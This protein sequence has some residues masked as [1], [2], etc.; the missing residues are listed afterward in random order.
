MDRVARARA[1]RNVALLIIVAL[2]QKAARCGE[3]SVWHPREIVVRGPAA[4]E[5]DNDPNPF[6]DIRLTVTL[7][8]PTGQSYVVPGFFDGDGKSEPRGDVW[9]ARFTPDEAGTWRYRAEFRAGPHVAIDL[10]PDAGTALAEFAAEGTVEVG[11]RDEEAPGFEKWGRLESVPGNYLK[12]H[13]GPY[14][15]RGG[16]DEPENFLAYAGFPRTPPTHRYADHVVDW[17][18]GDP[19]WGDG[20]GRGII[21]ALNYLAQHEVNSIYFLLMNIGGDGRDV[22]PWTGEP[23]RRGSADNDNLHYDIS[24]LRQW[25]TVFRHAQQRGIFLHAVFNEAEEANKRELDDGELGPE[26]KLYY[27]EMIARFGHHLALQWNLCEEY[28]LNFDFG[29]QRLRD[30]ADYVRAVDPYDHPIAVHSAGDPV[31]ALEFTFG[32]PRFDVM[33]VQLNQRPIHLVTEALREASRS[34]GRPVPVS[35]DEFTLD[36]GQRASH[37]PVDDA[38]G[39]RREKLWPTY[40]SGGMIEFI[41]QD[42]LRTDS[43]KTPERE[44]LWRAMAIARRFMEEQLPFWEMEPCDALSQGAA[45]L[46]VG[47]GRG[48]TVSLGAQVFAKPGEAYAVYFPTASSTGTLDLTALTGQA[49]LR[50]FNPRSGEFV[51]APRE[52]AAGALVALGPP[53]ADSELDWVAL[54]R[55]GNVPAPHF[56]GAHWERRDPDDAGLDADRLAQF[57]ERVGGDGCIVRDGCLVHEWGDPHAHGDWASAAKPVLSTLL[58][59]AVEKGK[60]ASVDAPVRDAGWPLREKDAGMTFRHLANMTSGYARG[61]APGEAWAYNDLAIELYARSLERVFGKS[62]DAALREGLPEL[63]FEDGEFFGSRD[64]VGVRASP[65]DFAR[66]AWFWLNEGQWNGQPLL[67]TQTMRDGLRPGVPAD[68]PRTKLEGEDYLR[69]GSYGGG[70]DQAAFG[71]G[72]YGFNFWFNRPMAGRERCWMSLP[73]D[74]YQAN[75]HWSRHTVTVVPGLQLVIV[76]RRPA[77]DRLEDS[78]GAF[79]ES[80]RLVAEAGGYRPPRPA[81]PLAPLGTAGFES[82]AHHWRRIRDEARVIQAEANQPAYDPARVDEIAANLLLFQRDNGG[83]PKDYDMH[84]VLTPAQREAVLVSRGRVDTSFDNSNVHSQVDYLA[85]AY[86]SGR[87]SA[88]RAACLRGFDFMLAAQYSDGGFPQRWPDPQGYAAHIT[89]NDGVMIGILNVLHDAAR[90]APHWSWLDAERRASAQRAVE[91]GVDCV[92]KCQIRDGARLTGWCQQHARDSYEPV[93]ARTFELAS[94]CPQETTEIVQFL[95]RQRDPAPEVVT[96][97]EAA[98]RWLAESQLRGVGVDRVPAPEIEFERHRA[99]FDVVV[100]EDPA[101]P[102]IWARHYELGTQRPVFAGRDGVKRYALSEI[103]RERRTGTPWYGVWPQTLL[104]EQYPAWR[105]K[106]EAA[107]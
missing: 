1:A 30:F 38:A 54:V 76:A 52:I 26:R 41:L 74:A 67:A 81:R 101:A 61:E 17:R 19:D 25:E 7:T 89:F 22:W 44:A 63:Q 33:S 16:V 66:L 79:D 70:S 58:L 49:T 98:A 65:R 40:F 20:Q 71:P 35:V 73:A 85:R 14:W 104:S 69:I 93:S 95:L 53:P 45:T 107:H 80:L 27:R 105:R 23:N 88:W 96:A 102:P 5:T 94:C 48:E 51:G 87:D 2:A 43:F 37:L 68:L 10:R 86:A 75:G 57:A 82:G 97:I 8:S 92:L 100:V 83:W 3:T 62:L 13:D 34:A 32:D 84:A 103:E 56:P 31:R 78:F 29:S 90:G 72:I 50:W 60:L 24:K 11:P 55:R 9:L 6:L 46:P 64:G 28:N 91:L 99:D 77:G 39:H 4:A 36:R 18:P 15:I 47:V 42:L 106:R 12:F 59:L 21:G